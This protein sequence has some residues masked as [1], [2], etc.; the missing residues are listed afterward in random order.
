MNKGFYRSTM[1]VPEMRRLLGLKKTDAYWLV[2]QGYFKSVCNE[3]SGRRI[4]IMRD[5]FEEWYASQFHYH[6]VTGEP[7]GAN[8][9]STT[10]SVEEAAKILGLT[11][12]A[13][14]C[15]LEKD[16]TLMK[17]V[18]VAGQTRIYTDSFEEWYINQYHYRKVTDDNHPG[19]GIIDESISSKE[20]ADLLGIPRKNLYS[21]LQ[22]AGIETVKIDGR[23]RIMKDSFDRYLQSKNESKE[24]EA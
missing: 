8:W 15:L 2:K 4:R 16:R 20:A 23:L 6:K 9:T 10:I 12:G 14:Y 22:T 13:I 19:R 5:S 17:T 24:E 11:S 3:P 7:P 21:R 18:I 1:T